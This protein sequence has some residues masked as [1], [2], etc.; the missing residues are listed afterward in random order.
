MCNCRATSA[1]DPDSEGYTVKAFAICSTV[2]LLSTA[3][4]MGWMSS[5]ARGATLPKRFGDVVG[6]NSAPIS[7][8]VAAAIS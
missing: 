7:A 3:I 5:E 4:E 6:P 8:A 1:I 2:R